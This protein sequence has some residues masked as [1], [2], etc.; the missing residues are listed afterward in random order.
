MHPSI[1]WCFD[2]ES[3]KQ[4]TATQLLQRMGAD[5]AA[6][7]EALYRDVKR[8]MNRTGKPPVSGGCCLPTA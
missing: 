3:G 7:E 6:L 5:P 4:L 8:R 2:F 1:S